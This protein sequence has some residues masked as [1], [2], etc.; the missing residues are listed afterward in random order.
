[1]ACLP[2]YNICGTPELQMRVVSFTCAL[3][4]KK[5]SCAT[6]AKSLAFLFF[7]T[8]SCWCCVMRRL[9]GVLCEQDW[10]MLTYAEEC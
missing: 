3:L 8:Q 9:S 5:I 10:R 6:C 4:H 2:R 7:A 1:V